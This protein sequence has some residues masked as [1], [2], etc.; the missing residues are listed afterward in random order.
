MGYIPKKMRPRTYIFCNICASLCECVFAKDA[1]YIVI[2]TFPTFYFY[3]GREYT[4]CSSCLS[5][6]DELGY[7]ECI[8]CGLCSHKTFKYCPKCKGQ[9]IYQYSTEFSKQ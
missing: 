6:F 1:Y 8:Q 7:V 2:L 3:S 9:K 4:A 5:K